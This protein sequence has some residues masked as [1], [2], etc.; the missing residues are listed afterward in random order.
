MHV[1][2]AAAFV[3]S[4]ATC[5]NLHTWSRFALAVRSMVVNFAS[6]TF[7]CMSP[8][9]CNSHGIVQLTSSCCT[10]VLHSLCVQQHLYIQCKLACS[11]QSACSEAREWKLHRFSSASCSLHINS[12]ANLY[13]VQT[14]FVHSMILAEHWTWPVHALYVQHCQHA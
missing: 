4:A 13:R 11:T 12:K 3:R 8:G 2:Y 5:I 10:W 14:E 1:D 9:Q 6:C 7:T